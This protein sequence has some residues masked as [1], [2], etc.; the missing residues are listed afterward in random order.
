MW[1]GFLDSALR[2]AIR[3]PLTLLLNG[4]PPSGHVV[5]CENNHEMKHSTY[6]KEAYVK[7]W[8]AT[9]NMSPAGRGAPLFPF[10]AKFSWEIRYNGGD[11]H[12]PVPPQE[13][14]GWPRVPAGAKKGAPAFKT[15]GKK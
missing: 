15:K 5:L 13:L 4:Y 3:P 11:H 10:P 8:Y 7:G 6:D 1:V 14:V 9:K 2:R 12:R